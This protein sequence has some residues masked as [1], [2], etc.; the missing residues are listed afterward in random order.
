MMLIL[1][2]KINEAIQIGDSIKLKILHIG[3]SQ[4]KVG[5]E[6]PADIRIFRAEIYTE[7]KAQ[8]SLATQANKSDVIKAA[9]M[10]SKTTKTS[11]Q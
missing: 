5:I 11:A 3:D 2:R 4:V 10:L 8:N 6:A 1:T 7:T 9:E